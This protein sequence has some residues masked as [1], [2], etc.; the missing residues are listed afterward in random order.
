MTH[1]WLRNA[2]QTKGHVTD[3]CNAERNCM[4]PIIGRENDCQG[5][6]RAVLP[7]LSTAYYASCY[8][9]QGRLKYHRAHR[10]VI[11]TYLGS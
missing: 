1:H 8:S 2:N 4:I 3:V 5:E 6:E 11:A 7:N 10:M 9:M